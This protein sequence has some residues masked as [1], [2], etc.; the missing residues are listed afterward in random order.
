MRLMAK[1][2]ITIIGCWDEEIGDMQNFCYLIAWESLADR[3]QRWPKFNTDPEW[4]KIKRESA[5]KHGEM[6]RKT[7]NK[8]LRPTS[9]SPL[10]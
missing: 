3:E 8:F 10:S 9:Y 6:V 7:H 5:A 1:H 4:S 2:G